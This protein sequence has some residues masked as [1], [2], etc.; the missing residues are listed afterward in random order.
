MANVGIQT[1]VYIF[2][3]TV[4][5]NTSLKFYRTGTIFTKLHFICNLHIG[6]IG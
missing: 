5:L 6:P 2:K 1:I 3:D 4:A